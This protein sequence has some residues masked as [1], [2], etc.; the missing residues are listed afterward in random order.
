MGSRLT[1]PMYAV[2]NRATMINGI[3]APNGVS[4]PIIV[5][6]LGY[7]AT[8]TGI[9]LYQIV[10]HDPYYA[11]LSADFELQ[12]AS[13]ANTIAQLTTT[14]GGKNLPFTFNISLINGSTGAVIGADIANN[15]NNLIHMQ[16]VFQ[17]SGT[18]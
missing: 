13:V 7:T 1:L 18:A 10:T 14:T 8:R 3:F 5:S 9:G 12:L 6:G 2:T 15:A 17:N 4:A 11:L 16:L